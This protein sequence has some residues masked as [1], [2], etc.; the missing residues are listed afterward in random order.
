MVSWTY[1]DAR[2]NLEDKF[3]IVVMLSMV[4]IFAFVTWPLV[5]VAASGTLYNIERTRN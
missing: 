5:V 3:E 2:E 1:R 4:G